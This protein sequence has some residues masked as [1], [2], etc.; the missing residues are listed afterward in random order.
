MIVIDWL[1]FVQ[2]FIAAMLASVTVVTFYALGLRLLVRAGRLHEDRGHRL[3]V[4]PGFG[5]EPKRRA[6]EVLGDIGSAI[7]KRV[8]GEGAREGGE[9]RP[10]DFGVR[11]GPAHDG[12]ASEGRDDRIEHAVCIVRLGN[13]DRDLRSRHSDLPLGTSSD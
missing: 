7:G 4:G 13:L 11:E 3:F 6:C 12:I 1:A 9:M 2:V 10:I 5:R 8:A